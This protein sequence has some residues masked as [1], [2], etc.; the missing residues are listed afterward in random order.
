MG[1][2]VRRY[3]ENTRISS[4]FGMFEVFIAMLYTWSIYQLCIS[5]GKDLYSPII[6]VLT[7]LIFVL[8]PVIS[9]S[10]LSILIMNTLPILLLPRMLQNPVVERAGKLLFYGPGIVGQLEQFF[11]MVMQLVVFFGVARWTQGKSMI[12]VNLRGRFIIALVVTTAVT[13]IASL[14]YEV[15]YY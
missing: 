8:F 7:C 9:R 2:V 10:Y 5:M 12:Q 13:A 15:P 14:L 4:G 11:V 6:P 3:A 1:G